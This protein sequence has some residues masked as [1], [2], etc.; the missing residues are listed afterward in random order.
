MEKNRETLNGVLGLPKEDVDQYTK[1][2]VDK[3]M[4][5]N[6]YTYST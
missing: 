3:V 2:A 1:I 5:G 4:S 6:N